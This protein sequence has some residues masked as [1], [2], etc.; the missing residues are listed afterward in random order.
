MSIATRS[1]ISSSY[2][3]YKKKVRR[4]F[5]PPLGDTLARADVQFEEADFD[6]R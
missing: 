1:K 6:L 2:G 5:L 4:R 3:E